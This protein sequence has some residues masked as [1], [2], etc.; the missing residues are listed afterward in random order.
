[1]FRFLFIYV[2]FCVILLSFQTLMNASAIHVQKTASAPTQLVAS[3]AFVAQV[4]SK[5]EIVV[6]VRDGKTIRCC[7]RL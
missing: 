6:K 2:L 7:F 5:E 3:S 4:S 1:M